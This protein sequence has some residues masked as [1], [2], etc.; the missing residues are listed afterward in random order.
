MDIPV[1]GTAF[2]VGG[3]NGVRGIP[4]LRNA[5]V[6]Q[7][8]GAA[9]FL[10]GIGGALTQSAKTTSVSALGSTESLNTGGVFK[11]GLGQGTQSG[12]GK[13]ADYYLKLAEQYSP[14]IPLNPGAM[15][16]IVFLKG[17]PIENEE[18]MKRYEATVNQARAD[19]KAG[20]NGQTITLPNIPKIPTADNFMSN[21]NLPSYNQAFN[22][23]VGAEKR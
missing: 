13:I 16:D 11:A 8:S 21:A 12:L 1:E 14:V 5:K 2:D 17:F 6:I 18:M 19:E 3:K 22:P 15:V 10:S 23:N 9:G 20:Q 7:A 4:N